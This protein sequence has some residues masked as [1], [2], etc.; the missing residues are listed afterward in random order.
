MVSGA[1]PRFV[2]H[3]SEGFLN[4]RVSGQARRGLTVTV[5]DALLL[6][7]VVGLFRTE[8][9]VQQNMTHAERRAWARE[10]GR[11]L[12]ERLNIETREAE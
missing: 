8:S 9:V 4:A 3:E 5:H 10:Q 1:R 12:A 11:A 6:Y 2:V 7:R